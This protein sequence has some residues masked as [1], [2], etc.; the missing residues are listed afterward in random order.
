[1]NSDGKITASEMKEMSYKF[2]QNYQDQ[3]D[4]E[5]KN[6]YIAAVDTNKDGAIEYSEYMAFNY[7]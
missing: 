7:G 3:L 2:G 5:G 6:T 1:M 4:S